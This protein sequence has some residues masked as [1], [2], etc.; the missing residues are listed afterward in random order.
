MKIPT[1][2]T[3][4]KT[5]SADD[6]AA[7]LD[8]PSDRI[9]LWVSQGLLRPVHRN[10]PTFDF[11]QISIARTLREL[12]TAGVSLR[13][14]RRGI[15]KLQCQLPDQQG[16]ILS[17][18]GNVYARLESGELAQADGQLCLEIGAE[19]VP[20]SIAL[21][22][23]RT[24]RQA[25]EE[26]ISR[27]ADGD[28]T[29]A[30]GLYREALLTGGPNAEISFALAHALAELGE[31]EQAAERYRQVVELDSQNSDAWN[32]LGT[33]LSQIGQLEQARDAFRRAIEANAA[34]GRARY[35]LAEVLDELGRGEEAVAHWREYLRQDNSSAWA[36][37]ARRRL[38]AL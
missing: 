29:G 34:N 3:P 22:A 21:Q 32:N 11:R 9:C 17:S 7:I 37:H 33:A 25:Y 15:E 14:I 28:L 27:E 4:T 12:V 24:A 26:G 20:Q 1:S 30:V 23:P 8:V 2:D 16:P 6:V 36:A 13:K 31:H 10:P 35:N 38:A 5:Y 18:D 19:P